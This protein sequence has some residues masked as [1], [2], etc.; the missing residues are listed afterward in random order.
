MEYKWTQKREKLKYMVISTTTAVN[1][2]DDDKKG[3]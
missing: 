3:C 2:M 1:A